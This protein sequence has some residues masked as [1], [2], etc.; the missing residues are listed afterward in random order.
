MFALGG[1]FRKIRVSEQ[2]IEGEHRR[3]SMCFSR[4]TNHSSANISSELRLPKLLDAMRV[5]PEIL[6]ALADQHADL[7]TRKVDAA[8]AKLVGGEGCVPLRELTAD[9]RCQ[10][11]YRESLSAIF[12]P[13]KDV[14]KLVNDQT[15]QRAKDRKAAHLKA[16]AE[17]KAAAAAAAGPDCDEEPHLD[18]RGVLLQHF[19]AVADR[20]VFFKMPKT[21]GAR[22]FDLADL[23]RGLCRS[24]SQ[25]QLTD[26]S[27]HETS[28]MDDAPPLLGQL[29]IEPQPAFSSGSADAAEVD[30]HADAG[31][32]H[33]I[34]RVVHKN[35]SNL[36]RPTKDIGVMPSTIIAI[37]QYSIVRCAPTPD[38]P[39]DLAFTVVANET[40][41]E[42]TNLFS[43]TKEC[44][45]ALQSLETLKMTD[46]KPIVKARYLDTLGCPPG[47]RS[48]CVTL[49]HKM[50]NTNAFCLSSSH[51]PA[52]GAKG[53]FHTPS[54][55]SPGEPA[56][57]QWLEQRG[58]LQ[59]LQHNWWAIT[60][61]GSACLRFAYSMRNSKP[62]YMVRDHLALTD[63]TTMELLLYLHQHGWDAHTDIARGLVP[64]S[65]GGTL[66]FYVKQ[67]LTSK[68]HHHYLLALC[69]AADVLSRGATAIYHSH[70]I[71]YYKCLLLLPAN[72]VPP[73]HLGTYYARLLGKGRAQGV[74]LAIEDDEPVLALPAP[75]PPPADGPDDSDNDG[76][77]DVDDDIPPVV[78]A[79]PAGAIYPK[80]PGLNVK[81]KA[82]AVTTTLKVKPPPPVPEPADPPTPPAAEPVLPPPPHA[83]GPP[84]KKHKRPAEPKSF[85]HGIFHVVYDSEITI[86]HLHPSYRAYCPFHPGCSKSSS[87]NKPSE[88]IVKLKLR[89]WCNQAPH[90]RVA[91]CSLIAEQQ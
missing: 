34:F 81:R 69:T 71:D 65:L 88:D 32:D 83:D 27:S 28:I 33:I 63:L 58:V 9:E 38:N 3:V 49:L 16:E 57:L 37:K 67:K 55:T 64:Y 89:Y 20:E 43:D 18:L 29:T 84:A 25:L 15:N 41:M 85:W 76:G 14:V 87:I 56:A 11:L 2:S 23:S 78:P 21:L 73:H 54:D 5:R 77:G 74:L 12:D 4:A 75:L 72:N 7:A 44:I 86:S 40:P 70:P 22:N 26:A 19:R 53:Y 52:A 68:G 6:L 31:A 48:P 47:L 80:K 62:V 10:V 50:V 46:V 59:S 61:A 36:S 24:T 66:D 1:A 8:L 79:G 60:E 82:D 30:S 90:N 17:A 35:P 42:V 91:L 39:D 45:K 51:Q 13:C